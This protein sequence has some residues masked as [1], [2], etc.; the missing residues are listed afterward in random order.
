MLKLLITVPN[1]KYIVQFRGLHCTLGKWS[2][3]KKQGKVLNK[4]MYGS[5]KNKRKWFGERNSKTVFPSPISL[6]STRG[7]GQ[8]SSRRLTVLNKLFMEH[9]TDLMV[10]GE[11]AE[12]LVGYGIQISRV[13][14]N[15]DFHGVNVFWFGKDSTQDMEVGRLLK[16]V[17]GGIRHELSQLRLIGQVPKLAFMKDKTYGLGTEVDSVLRHLDFGKDVFTNRTLIGKNEFEL[18][19]KLSHEVREEIGQLDIE[20]PIFW[21]EPLPNMRHDVLGLNHALIINKI[22]RSLSKTKAAWVQYSN[23]E[24]RTRYKNVEID[25]SEI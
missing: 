16:R 20:T 21:D 1:I 18:Q 8:E 24:R 4:L 2:S 15:T 19:T 7:Q 17:A 3:Y 10:T 12:E 5:E 14:I 13:R 6:A 22:K 9:I 11:Y 25:F 23:K